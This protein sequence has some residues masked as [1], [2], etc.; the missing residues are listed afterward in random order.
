MQGS[1]E[2]IP[3]HEIVYRS[4]RDMI[5]YGEFAPGQAVTIQGLG[6]QLGVSM[7]PVREAIRRLT[8]EGA[9]EFMGNRRVC[10]PR[11]GEKRFAELVFARRAIEPRLAVMG[12]EGMN[13]A[14]IAALANADDALNAAIATGDVHGYM[15]F[16]HRFHFALYEQSESRVLLPVTETLWL[17]FGPLFRIICGRYGTSNIIDHHEEAIDMLKKGDHAGVAGAIRADI[18]QGFEIIRRIH[19]WN[20]I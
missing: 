1:I 6:D 7:T 4:V 12:S 14:G 18:E 15:R 10:V 13:G 17:R 20:A 19:G 2:K 8:A 16:N 11:M 5:L 3:S 9:L